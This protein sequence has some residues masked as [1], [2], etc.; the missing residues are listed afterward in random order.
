MNITDVGHTNM[1]DLKKI[2]VNFLSSHS[3]SF[4]FMSMHLYFVRNNEFMILQPSFL[5]EYYFL[6]HISIQNDL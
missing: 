2:N 1:D 3:F 6:V 5:N 4:A